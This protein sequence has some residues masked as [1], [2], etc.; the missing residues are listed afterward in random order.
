MCIATN[1]S[2]AMPL[3]SQEMCF[4]ASLDGCGG[5]DL[6]TPWIYIQLAGK[7]RRGGKRQIQ[8]RGKE[9]ESDR[10]GGR[11]KEKEREGKRWMT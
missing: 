5:G 10:Q 2:L 11:E 8:T 4:C 9:A 3:S 1:G 7:E 6:T